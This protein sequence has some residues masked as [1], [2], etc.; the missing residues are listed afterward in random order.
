MRRAVLLFI[1]SGLLLS[2]CN[3]AQSALDPAGQEAERIATL[4]WW[5][6]AGTL[7]VWVLVMILALYC[8]YASPES[9]TPWRGNLIIVGG[10][11]VLPAVVLAVLLVFGLAMIPG[12]VSPA[13]QGSLRIQVDGELWWWRVRYVSATNPNV[14]L[15]NEIHLPVGEQVEFQLKSDNVIHSFWIPALGGKMDMMPG[16]STRLV[17]TPTRT[18]TYRGVCAEYCGD[19]HALM[20]FEVVVESRADF[21]RWLKL[22][23]KPATKPTQSLAIRGQTS[24]LSS[25]CGSCHSIRGTVNDG[26]I[27]PDLT[28]VGSRLKVAAGTLPCEPESLAL[29]IASTKE[30]KP[31]SRMPHFSMLK[32]DE[33]RA[34]AAYLKGLR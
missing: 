31:G 20:K 18:G 16:R 22:Q 24:F 10:G 4:F 2:G 27:G 6:V 1:F 33:L 29:W 26:I 3:G 15:A 12:L 34:I 21:E 13:R 8:V 30:L 28:H 9:F 17:L 11:A 25:G 19:S 14:V 23:S 32:P 7:L 5:M